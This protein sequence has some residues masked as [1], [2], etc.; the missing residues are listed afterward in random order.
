MIFFFPRPLVRGLELRA[1][2]RRQA[3]GKQRIALKPIHHTAHHT[4]HGKPK[5]RLNMF[6]MLNSSIFFLA[7]KFST[8]EKA[9]PKKRKEKLI[10]KT[11]LL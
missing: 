11:L 6:S 4:T 10:Y 8:A 5:A 7:L 3:D 1:Y 9:E 2:E